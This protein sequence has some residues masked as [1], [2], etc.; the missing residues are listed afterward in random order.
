MNFA[1]FSSRL[2][3]VALAGVFSGL[4]IP[5]GPA[6]P[7][8]KGRVTQVIRDVKIL[9]GEA[10]ARP[11]AVNDEV[12]PGTAVRTGVESRTELTFADLTIAR[13]GANT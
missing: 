2:R 3:A 4:M 12:V 1:I 11:A 8:Q 9:P 10:A 13:L 6:A 7:L 5:A